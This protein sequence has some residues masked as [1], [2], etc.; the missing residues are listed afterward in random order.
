MEQQILK[1][2]RALRELN[3]TRM[4]TGKPADYAEYRYL[5]GYLTALLTIETFIVEKQKEEDDNE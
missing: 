5:C 3:E 2:I 1:E 4:I